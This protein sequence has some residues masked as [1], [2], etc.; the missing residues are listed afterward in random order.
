MFLYVEV[1]QQWSRSFQTMV[2]QFMWT[3]KLNRTD[4]MEL[5]N[6]MKRK[7]LPSTHSLS[8]GMQCS[9]HLYHTILLCTFRLLHCMCNGCNFNSLL[10]LQRSKLRAV[11]GQI[12]RILLQWPTTSISGQYAWPTISSLASPTQLVQITSSRDETDSTKKLYL[13][14]ATFRNW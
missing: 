10:L 5:T 3:S 12:P 7:P 6:Q 4:L 13:K 8:V 14:Y 9:S 1:T 11:I 2:C